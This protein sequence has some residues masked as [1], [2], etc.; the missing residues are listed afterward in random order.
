MS[1]KHGAA[2]AER[3]DGRE[4]AARK[5]AIPK[6]AG[7]KSKAAASGPT[8]RMGPIVPASSV[9][10]NTLIMV[11][12]IMT[13]LAAL[14]VGAAD[15][16][17]RTA[18]DWAR[19]VVRETTIQIRPAEGR[20]MD[21]SVARAAEIGRSAAG[22]VDVRPYSKQETARLLEPWLGTGLSFD[23]L[24]IPRLVVL[25][26]SGETPFD[27]VAL[28]EKLEREVPGATLDDHRRF[29]D[30]LVAMARTIVWLGV[31]VLALM[32]TATVLSV[33]FATRGAMA[34]NRDIVQVLHFV[35]ARDGYIA[36][37]FQRRF[38]RLGLKGGLAGGIAAFLTFMVA[39]FTAEQGVGSAAVDQMDALFGRFQ[40][41]AS[42]YAGVVAI[43]LL[44][45]ALTSITSRVTVYR[46]LRA[47]N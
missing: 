19:D 45:A 7:S 8:R 20:D 18:D 15:L 3:R 27:A 30:R 36:G 41:G 26:L 28:K 40:V 17:R 31:G 38:L 33:V 47:M 11:I 4:G 14:T 1:A 21:A 34:G 37:Q 25:R 32:L 43:V 10:G 29:L 46:T 12:A 23:D 5:P 39:G 24:P 16:V 35:G 22:V 42:A 9:S 13:Y 44:I 2:P 6:A